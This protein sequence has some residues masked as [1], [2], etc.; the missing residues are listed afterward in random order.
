[1]VIGVL[2]TCDDGLCIEISHPGDKDT[3]LVG[4][5]C[6][7]KWSGQRVRIGAPDES[8]TAVLG[9][10]AV[11]ELVERLGVIEALDGAV[12]SIKQRARGHW[13]GGLLVGLAAA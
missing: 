11:S 5:V 8:L 10:V 3:Y 1:M 7:G 13:A 12:G 4:R 6:G 9:M 2:V